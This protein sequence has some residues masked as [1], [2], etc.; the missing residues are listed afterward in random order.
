[1]SKTI[2]Y[3]VPANYEFNFSKSEC[4]KL[5]HVICPFDLSLKERELASL[6]NDTSSGRFQSDIAYCYELSKIMDDV[7]ERIYVNPK[8]VKKGQDGITSGR[9]RLCIGRKLNRKVKV[10]IT[11]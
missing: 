4:A 9:H 7:H 3:K 1:M 10:Y 8:K 6:N 11:E 5:T 2:K